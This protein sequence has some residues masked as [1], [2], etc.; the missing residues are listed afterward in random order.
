MKTWAAQLPKEIA[1]SFT[2]SNQ[3]RD[4]ILQ[5]LAGF[6]G[7]HFDI[8]AA[9]KMSKACE[10]IN[11]TESKTFVELLLHL[12]GTVLPE[13]WAIIAQAFTNQLIRSQTFFRKTCTGTEFLPEPNA[14]NQAFWSEGSQVRIPQ[15]EYSAMEQMAPLLNKEDELASKHKILVVEKLTS[16]ICFFLFKLSEVP[17]KA[18][19]AASQHA[20]EHTS[21]TQA[22]LQVAK[23]YK[24]VAA[25]APSALIKDFVSNHVVEQVVAWTQKVGKLLVD[26]KSAI[27]AKWENMVESKNATQIKTVLFSRKTHKDVTGCLDEISIISGNVESMVKDFSSVASFLQPSQLA[28]L[29]EV[30]E[31]HRI[32][33]NYATSLHGLN[34]ILHKL[35]PKTARERSAAVR[36]CVGMSIH[37]I[38]IACLH[39]GLL[40]SAAGVAS[41]SVKAFATASP[42]KLY[43]LITCYM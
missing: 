38:F 6:C 36:E 18:E 12:T 5:K 1:A 28:A 2:C 37:Q 34:L 11:L 29:K 39:L 43:P 17:F 40:D 8:H 24:E 23:C 26:C 3:T 4:V 32:I 9:D 31:N 22:A 16:K 33:R 42:S 15:G 41:G 25:K 27:P 30:I 14:N 35:P 7:M 21:L 19:H 10:A 13:V 20:E